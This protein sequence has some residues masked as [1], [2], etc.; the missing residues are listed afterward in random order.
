MLVCDCFHFLLI[1]NYLKAFW[2][3]TQLGKASMQKLS[4]YDIAELKIAHR[5]TLDCSIIAAD[6]IFPQ[7]FRQTTSHRKNRF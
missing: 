5:P 3:I 6:S 2:K 7:Y 1:H 4:F